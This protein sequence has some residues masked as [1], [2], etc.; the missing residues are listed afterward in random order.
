MPCFQLLCQVT[1]Q[2]SPFPGDFLLPWKSNASSA[3]LLHYLQAV[4]THTS[5]SS[6]MFSLRSSGSAHSLGHPQSPFPSTLQL[7]VALWS[8]CHLGLMFHSLYSIPLVNRTCFQASLVLPYTVA[9]VLFRWW[10]LR[11]ERDFGSL[12]PL[13]YRTTFQSILDQ[14]SS[15]LSC[16]GVGAWLAYGNFNY[17]LQAH[18]PTTCPLNLTRWL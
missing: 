12:S 7:T 1:F 2:L 3:T 9:F 6:S 11:I 15:T 16:L 14:L 5:P 13:H 10:N 18:H 17:C 8:A 4:S